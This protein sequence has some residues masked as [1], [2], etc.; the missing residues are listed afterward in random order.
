M[1]AE[2]DVLEKAKRDCDLALVLIVVPF[3]VPLSW[4]L[5][6][7]RYRDTVP[8][9]PQLRRAYLNWRRKLTA[10]VTL[11]TLL[12][13]G[14]LLVNLL[15]LPTP[16]QTSPQRIGVLLDPSDESVAK[17]VSVA[18]NS[19]A[20]DAQLQPG[21]QI[22]AIDDEPV[23]T[24][25]SLTEAINQGDPGS[26]RVLTVARDRQTLKL[27]VVPTSDA[28]AAGPARGLFESGDA[29]G[30]C[31]DSVQAARGPALLSLAVGL[32][33]MLLLWLYS[34]ARGGLSATAWGGAILAMALAP[35]MGA[36]VT[37][38]SCQQLGGMSQGVSLIGLVGQGAALLALGGAM[39]WRSRERLALVLG[40]KLGTGHTIARGALFMMASIVRLGLAA[41]V[42]TTLMP[43]LNSG[44]DAALAELFSGGG[45]LLGK[46]LVLLAAVIFA[47]LAEE[48]IFRGLVLPGLARHMAPYTAL[49]LTAIL[50]AIFH[51]PSHGGGA[52]IPGF[53]GVI[54]GWARLR[55]GG[56]RAPIALHAANNLFVTLLAWLAAA[57]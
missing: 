42:V 28:F 25:A 51:I 34:L 48:V 44:D 40:P 19:P 16:G 1:T 15:G 22:E 33:A 55:S 13:I 12:V 23:T 26:T 35:L 20:A 52:L 9:A 14:L 57:T 27:S 4:L 8:S 31:S 41:T 21:D 46:A 47:P 6:V 17:V 36:A 45:S 39:W 38:G 2:S 43:Q 3:M 24:I 30:D 54:F 5:L 29:S 56:L 53:L 32:S 49:W 37:Y 10:L 7:R 18:D 50:F 11:D